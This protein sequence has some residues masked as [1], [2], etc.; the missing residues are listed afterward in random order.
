MGL[1][2]GSFTCSRI[3]TLFVS[4]LVLVGSK[5]PGKMETDKLRLLSTAR[6]LRLSKPLW[7]LAAL[8]TI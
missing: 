8:G 5:G 4:L 1:G 2:G 3:D 7:G 6:M